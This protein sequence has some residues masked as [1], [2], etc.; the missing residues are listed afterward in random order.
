MCGRF[1]LRTPQAVLVEQ[2]RLK[3][4]PPLQ[5]RYNIAPTQQI[6]VVRQREPDQRE[7]AWMKGASCDFGPKTPAS[8][9]G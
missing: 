2:F 6:G 3:S 4:I 9:T 8:G 7:F 5:P 1:T